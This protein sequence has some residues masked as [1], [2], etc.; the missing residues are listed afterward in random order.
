V[1]DRHPHRAAAVA[2]VGR[3]GRNVAAVAAAGIPVLAFGLVVAVLGW[4]SLGWPLVHDAPLMHYIA[5]RIADGAVPYRDLFDMNFPGVYLLHLGVVTLLGPGDAAWRAFDL[6]WLGLGALAVGAFAGGWGT[7]A[8]VGAAL[9]FAAQH[10]AGGAWNAGQRDFLLCPFLVAGALAVARWAEGRTGTLGLAAGGVALGAGA[11]I[12]P[13]A[14]AF[15]LALA[16]VLGVVGSRRG[17]VA[18]RA[19]AGFLGS[20]AVA[21][22]AVVVWVSSLGGWPAWRDIL[23]DYL[24]P[25][26]SR[27][28]RP[29]R[30]G[31]HGW[32]VWAPIA[33]VAL[34]SVVGAGLGR[35]LGVRHLV[36]GLGVAYGVAHYLGQGKG[37]AYH[38][39]PFA[40]FVACLAFAELR[41][42]AG[43][44]RWLVAVPVAG[45]LVLGA[46][47]FAARGAEAAQ[48]PWIRTAE[49]RVAALV[50]DLRPI[51]ADSDT[52]QVLDTTDGGIH[53][54]L[55]LGVRQ[56]TRFIYDFHF[57]HDPD[58]PTIRR[59]REEL[60]RDLAARP[61][62][63]LVLFDRGW[64]AGG[65]E[66]VRAFPALAGWL[67]AWP[68]VARGDGYAIHA[69][70]DRP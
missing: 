54:L 14:V 29:A 23:V 57:F 45:A 55:R 56:P 19:V 65:P 35:R 21:P 49:Q 37:W 70:P 15:A 63:A 50:A 30:W 44:G 66:R 3:P 40:A 17:A 8:G 60:M 69:K 34:V 26:Y 38:L 68:V 64:P 2:A 5:W 52:V 7:M 6:G 31:H 48:A 47:Q 33:G 39:Y 18:S 22:L 46:L 10:L 32:E 25:L 28:G 4:R 9:V 16:V 43:A 27:L 36:G 53:A 13:H 61:P 62:R 11:T 24:V 58:T 67:D 41:V 1:S 20:V 59:L 51:V 12:K 42:L